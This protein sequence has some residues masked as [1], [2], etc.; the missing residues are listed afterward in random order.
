MDA[1]FKG[2]LLGLV[3]VISLGPIFF[4]L[5]Q[6]SIE[7]G[8]LAGLSV[9][10]GTLVSDAIY[11]TISLFSITAI[12]NNVHFKVALGVIGG[13][14]L[15]LFCIFSFFKKTVIKDMHIELPKINYTAIAIKGFLINTLN[16]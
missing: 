3:L 16:P 13:G 5:I 6:T 9:A 8:F 7:K 12:I 1:Y 10:C 14:I 15:I 2:M 4:F 11:I